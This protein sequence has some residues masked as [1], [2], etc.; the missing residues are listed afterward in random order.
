MT[1]IINFDLKMIFKHQINLGY[2]PVALKTMGK[3][4]FHKALMVTGAVIWYS[5][6]WVAAIFDFAQTAYRRSSS[7]C[8]CI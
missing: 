2:R 4:A 5:L 7:V 6:F 3:V 8:D 1:L